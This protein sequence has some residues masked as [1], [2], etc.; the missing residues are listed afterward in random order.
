MRLIKA[1]HEFEAQLMKEMLRP[2]T[3]DEGF[4]G[5]GNDSGSGGIL[6]DFAGEA[7]GQALSAHGGLGIAKS[8]VQSLSH[9]RDGAGSETAGAEGALQL[10]IHRDS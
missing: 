1:A 3:A 5:D 8:I 10:G 7:L 6:K 2:L 9:L 4:C